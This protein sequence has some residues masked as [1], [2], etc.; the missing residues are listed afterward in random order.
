MA[1]FTKKVA[2]EAD[3]ADA[4]RRRELEQEQAEAAAAAE[5]EDGQGEGVDVDNDDGWMN[6]DLRFEVDEKELTRRAEDEYAV[7]L[8]LPLRDHLVELAIMLVLR[9]VTR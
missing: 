7:S 6:H 4:R 9:I 2:K 5:E 1:S 8:T 3:E